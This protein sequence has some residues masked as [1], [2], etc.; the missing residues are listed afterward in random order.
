MT[1][2]EEVN[3]TGNRFLSG[4]AACGRIFIGALFLYA[5]ILKASDPAGF[6]AA[7]ANYQI[8]PAWA[9]NPAAIVLPWVEIAIGITLLI[10]FWIEGGS[11]MAAVLFAVFTAALGYNLLRGLDISCGCFSSSPQK[12]NW[13]YFYRDLA[14]TLLSG[15][16]FLFDNYVL[17]PAQW[18]VSQ[19]GKRSASSQQ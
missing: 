5:G 18:A 1:G 19:I 6:A 7:I 15:F 2:M 14:L 11:L 17:S 12:I 8:L 3:V 4:L 10:G 9:V 16:V 13:L